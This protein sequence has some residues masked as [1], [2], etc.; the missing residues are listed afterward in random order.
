MIK[1]SELPAG[2]V[3]EVQ[4]LPADGSTFLRLRE[5][6]LT[7]GTRLKLVRRAPLGDPI[8]I[9]VRGYHLSLRK[10]EAERIVVVPSG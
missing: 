1:L 10:D 4:D 5:M 2:G 6:G 8:Q 3:A 9:E 7:K